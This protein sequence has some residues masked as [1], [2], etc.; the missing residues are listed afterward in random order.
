MVDRLKNMAPPRVQ[1]AIYRTWFN[2]WCTKRRF[3]IKENCY[4]VFGCQ[5]RNTD[6]VEHYMVCPCIR[7]WAE[8]ELGIKDEGSPE[9]RGA[10]W[11]LLDCDKRS[12]F[13][14][15]IRAVRLAAV[16]RAYNYCRHTLQVKSG[17]IEGILDQ[18]AKEAVIGMD[19]AARHFHHR[20]DP[21]WR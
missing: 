7:R 20:K 12:D 9:E 17:E 6:S 4:C 10:S 13:E 21:G 19:G 16:Y 18:S 2:G 11:L 1:A 14:L 8:K 15:T 3:G 5:W